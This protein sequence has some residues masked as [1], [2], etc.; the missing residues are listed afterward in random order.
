MGKKIYQIEKSTS[1]RSFDGLKNQVISKLWQIRPLPLERLMTEYTFR[2]AKYKANHQYEHLLERGRSFYLP[3]KATG[4]YIHITE[5]GE[6]PAVILSHGWASE[7]K[8]LTSFVPKLLEAGFSVILYDQPAH[9]KSTSI[10]TNI[11]DFIHAMESIIRYKKDVHAIVAHSM[12]TVAAVFNLHLFQWIKKGVLIAPICDY[13]EELK[14]WFYKIGL[15]ETVMS[16]VVKYLEE[17]HHLK[18]DAINPKNVAPYLNAAEVLLVHDINDRHTPFKGSE[19]LNLLLPKSQ[20][21]KT[22]KLGHAKILHNEEVITDI[23]DFLKN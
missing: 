4:K 2:P 19:R 9:G 6:G 3:V 14:K 22:Q 20:I 17:R 5:I 7:K 21:K 11:F 13:E 23:I 10:S 8:Q 12:S 18:L 1:V 15:P 16:D